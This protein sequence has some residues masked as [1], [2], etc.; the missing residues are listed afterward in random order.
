MQG[1]QT[2]MGVGPPALHGVISLSQAVSVTPCNP[3]TV[4]LMLTASSKR[5]HRLCL[6][7]PPPLHSLSHKQLCPTIRNTTLPGTGLAPTFLS[8]SDSCVFPAGSL[9]SQWF[10]GC[11]LKTLTQTVITAF[12]SYVSAQFIIII[13]TSYVPISSELKLSDASKPWD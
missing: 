13:V 12:S 7:L 2:H 8:V 10:M 1:S 5:S 4:W 3:S 11:A 6:H 9:C